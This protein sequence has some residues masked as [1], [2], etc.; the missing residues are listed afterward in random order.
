[1]KRVITSAST[2]LAILLVGMLAVV[3]T[4]RLG[5]AQ[6]GTPPATSQGFVGTWEVAQIVAGKPAGIRFAT[7]FSDGTILTTG[8]AVT[9]AA[10]GAPNKLVF[11]STAHG[12]WYSTGPQTATATFSWMRS[13]ENGKLLGMTTIHLNST[14]GADGQTFHNVATVVITDASGKVL[15]TLPAG[16][17][18]KRLSAEPPD[19]SVIGTPTS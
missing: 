2:C 14:L 9:A 16:G 15:S 4:S 18:G 3:T 1:M 5:S 19:P 7:W 17:D 11:N 8:P 13:D 6:T 10:P 12:E